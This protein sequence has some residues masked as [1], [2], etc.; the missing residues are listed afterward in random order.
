[1]EQ[2]VTE[3]L[4]EN[5]EKNGQTKPSRKLLDGEDSSIQKENKHRENISLKKSNG[6]VTTSKVE[7]RKR[8]ESPRKFTGG[9]LTPIK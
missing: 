7:T 1:M 9:V 6:V 5:Q 2:K 3:I 4:L 8:E